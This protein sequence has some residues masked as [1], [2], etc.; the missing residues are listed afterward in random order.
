MIK[1]I[2]ELTNE[3][4]KENYY[5]PKI[6]KLVNFT[7]NTPKCINLLGSRNLALKFLK[8]LEEEIEIETVVQ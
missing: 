3:E 8:L 1:K 2:Y 5:N 7:N 4:L 6:Q